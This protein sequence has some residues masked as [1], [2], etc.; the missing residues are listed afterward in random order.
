MSN[1]SLARSGHSKLP[2]A[3]DDRPTFVLH[4][5][6]GEAATSDELDTAIREVAD[7][8]AHAELIAGRSAKSAQMLRAL[9]KQVAAMVARRKAGPLAAADPEP[10]TPDA[11]FFG[12]AESDTRLG[13]AL[14]NEQCSR[15]DRMG[16]LELA[17]AA[18]VS[19]PAGATVA[20][21]GR[22]SDALAAVRALSEE[23]LIA[24]FS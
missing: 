8:L 19:A 4:E 15:A 22:T 18:P 12:R 16:E 23:E 14:A 11:G 10:A 1:E 6:S 20:P 13:E 2:E 9:A 17:T 21:S 5:S 7:A 24:L 3:P